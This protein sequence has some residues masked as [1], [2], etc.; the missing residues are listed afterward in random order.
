ML[1]HR[2]S[3]LKELFTGSWSHFLFLCVCVEYEGEPSKSPNCWSGGDIWF[4]Y[5]SVRTCDVSDGFI[6]NDYGW[7]ELGFVFLL[8]GILLGE[9]MELLVIEDFLPGGLLLGALLVQLTDEV[10][11]G[12][13]ITRREDGLFSCY[14]SVELAVIISINQSQSA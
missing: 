8:E 7:D 3:R 6:G 12:R 5:L 11:N 10:G 4:G 13:W 14:P 9:V 1:R 2:M